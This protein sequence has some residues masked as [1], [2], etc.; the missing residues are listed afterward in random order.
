MK[1][2]ATKT[3]ERP[4]RR[5]RES[6]PTLRYTPP[7]PLPIPTPRELYL[8][9]LVENDEYE[10]TTPLNLPGLLVSPDAITPPAPAASYST[11]PRRLDDVLE[12]EDGDAV[13]T[14]Q[15]PGR[16][17]ADATESARAWPPPSPDPFDAPDEYTEVA[18]MQLPGLIIA[19]DQLPAPE[20]PA[21]SPRGLCASCVH[22]PTCD[23]PRPESGVW[24]C[25]EYE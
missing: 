7:M 5:S 14:C 22:N 8:A 2:V 11:F 10:F 23:F 17:I 1:A 13:S 25:E 20:P 3:I 9:N 24:R 21:T 15:L 16:L 19:A 18:A 4:A 6:E 12:T